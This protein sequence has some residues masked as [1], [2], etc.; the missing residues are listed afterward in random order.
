MRLTGWFEKWLWIDA[1]CIDQSDAQERTHQVEIMSEIF[2]RA[3]SVISW[4]GP[5]YDNSEH[6]MNAIAGYPYDGKTSKHTALNRTEL[7]EAIC[8]LC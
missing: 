6:A 5:A 3:D 2:G 8:S 7:S 1:L 4:L